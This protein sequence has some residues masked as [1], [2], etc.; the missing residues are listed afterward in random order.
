M[1]LFLLTLIL[2]FHAQ[3]LLVFRLIEMFSNKETISC[4]YCEWTGRKDKLAS[5]SNVH[6]PRSKVLNRLRKEN[7]EKIP[8][9]YEKQRTAQHTI[10]PCF[11][12]LHFVSNKV[13]LRAEDKTAGEIFW[14]KFSRGGGNFLFSERFCTSALF[15]NVSGYKK[16]FMLTLYYHYYLNRHNTPSIKQKTSL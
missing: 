7:V 10:L 4:F 11:F 8:M 1:S 13:D 3:H 14:K 12:S 16:K 9:S 15:R 5:H 6:N 2:M